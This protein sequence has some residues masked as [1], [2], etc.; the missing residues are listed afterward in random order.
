MLSHA[1]MQLKSLSRPSYPYPLAY[2]NRL[3]SD[4][5]KCSLQRAAAVWNVLRSVLT[6][7]SL[8]ICMRCFSKMSFIYALSSLSKHSWFFAYLLFITWYG[9][10]KLCFWTVLS[11]WEIYFK[12]KTAQLSCG[13]VNLGGAPCECLQPHLILILK[14]LFFIQV[15]L[16]VVATDKSLVCRNHTSACSLFLFRSIFLPGITIVLCIRLCISWGKSILSVC[17]HGVVNAFVACAEE[18]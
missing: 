12:T 3:F 7:F 11:I 1:A 10:I 2:I 16:D 9:E 13:S 8:F 4:L 15:L 14:V 6:N 18:L 17:S 5:Q